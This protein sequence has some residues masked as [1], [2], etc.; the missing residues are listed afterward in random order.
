MFFRVC[1]CQCEEGYDENRH[2]LDTIVLMALLQVQYI[3]FL[4]KNTHIDTW[5]T[6][7][8]RNTLTW[9]NIFCVY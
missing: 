5:V 2:R 8:N 4:D 7:E 6:F 9:S 1:Q 3:S